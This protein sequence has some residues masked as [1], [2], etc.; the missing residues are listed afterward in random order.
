VQRLSRD[1]GGWISTGC[2]P[3]SS[4]SASHKS[5]A[6]EDG[7]ALLDVAIAIVVLMIMLLPVAYLLSTSG[8]TAATNQH[9]LTAQSLAASWLEQERAAGAQ[10]PS[11]PPSVSPPTGTTPSSWPGAPAETE[12]IGTTMYSVYVAGGWC[13]YQGS[14]VPWSNG[15]ATTTNANLP[16]PPLTFFIAV[17]VAWGLLSSV[18]G[19]SVVEYSSVQSQPEWLVGGVSPLTLTSTPTGSIC[20]LALK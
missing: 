19:G 2:D 20:P 14:G 17:K 15:T 1:S 6:E 13:V 12:Q 7:F 16:P 9:R 18:N 8:K 11:G 4:R 5:P 3:V 10:S